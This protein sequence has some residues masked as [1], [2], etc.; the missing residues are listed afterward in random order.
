ML[1]NLLISLHIL[2]HL[3]F[4]GL[5]IFFDWGIKSQ[6]D[7]MIK[8]RKDNL[9]S[10]TS[11]FLNIVAASNN[12]YAIIDNKVAMKLDQ[13]MVSSGTG[14]TLKLSGTGFTFGIKGT[15]VD[16]P[17][18]TTSQAGGTFNTGSTVSTMM[19]T[20]LHPLYITH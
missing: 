12:L 11:I 18:L 17:S 19:P 8:I 10:S 4:G 9:L 6:I 7:A 2:E 13:I 16:V 15:V 14:W 5:T 1:Q 3:W 20:I